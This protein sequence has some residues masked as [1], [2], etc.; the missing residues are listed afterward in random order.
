MKK[1][2]IDTSNIVEFEWDEGN[3]EK[4]ELKHGVTKEE[5]EDV[6]FNEPQIVAEDQKHSIKEMRY[7]L[8]GQTGL[9][10]LLNVIF[11]IRNN[12][13]RVIS[14][15]DQNKKEREIYIELL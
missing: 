2:K 10:R 15:R 11:T 5:C 14:A 8:L 7:S 12:K 1:K 4:N 9:G 13:I 3:I 6:F